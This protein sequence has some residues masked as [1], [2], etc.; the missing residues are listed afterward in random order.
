MA[1]AGVPIHV[2]AST[3]WQTHLQPQTSTCHVT[4]VSSHPPIHYIVEAMGR[5][6]RLCICRGRR[7]RMHAIMLAVQHRRPPF[8][9]SIYAI[10]ICIFN[11][12]MYMHM[13]STYIH[14]YRCI[15]KYVQYMC[16]CFL[17]GWSVTCM[18]VCRPMLVSLA[19]IGLQPL[20]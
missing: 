6:L 8:I 3:C 13:Y 1:R 16:A 15:Y 14:L 11:I 10:Y 5:I 17:C 9:Y 18:W 4:T 19:G 12:Q 20:A 2:L 7:L